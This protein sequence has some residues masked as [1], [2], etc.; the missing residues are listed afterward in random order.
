MGN[1]DQ[2]LMQS[3]IILETMGNAKTLRNNNSSRFGKYMKI[4]FDNE[5]NFNLAGA[6]IETYLLE[7]S[8]IVFQI[9]G[10]RN[11]HIFYQIANGASGDQKGQWKIG[12]ASDY[13]YINQS[14]CIA[15]DGVDEPKMFDLLG[16]ALASMGI[17]DTESTSLYTG[18]AGI[19][20]MGNIQ[21]EDETTS[22]GDVA[23]VSNMEVM[24]NAAELFG[25]E[26]TDLEKC[27]REKTLVAA[28]RGSVYYVKRDSTQAGYARDAMGKT[29]YQALFDWVVDKVRV[30]LGY[31]DKPLP[32]IAVLDIFG[33][34]HFQTNDF[35]QLLINFTNEALQGSFNKAVFISEQDL[36]K[37]EGIAVDAITPPDN[38]ICLE[39]LA[40]KKTG[41]MA[42][43]EQSGS[44][45]QP[46]DEKFN[47]ALHREHK[48]ARCF[49]RPHPKDIATTFIISHYAAEV[50]Y[51]VGKFL[52]K[53][54]DS[55]PP[56][57]EAL[58]CDCKC[59]AVEFIF[60]KQV[61]DRKKVEE[62]AEKAASKGVR[63][64]KRGKKKAQTV[65]GTFSKQITELIG[66][67]NETKMSY[68]LC[69]KPNFAMQV[70]VFDRNSVMEQLQCT[71]T[72]QACEVLRVGLPTRVDYAEIAGGFKKVLP[73]STLAVVS[74]GV[75]DKFLVQG[76]L[77]AFSVDSNAYA[78]G[79]TKLFFKT[80][81]IAVLESLMQKLN[82]AADSEQVDFLNKRLKFFVIRRRWRRAFAYVCAEKAWIWLFHIFR[83]QSAAA[84]IQRMF[85]CYIARK[86]Y[87]M[88]KEGE[89]I[90]AN[91]E[92]SAK[93]ALAQA[94]ASAQAAAAQVSGAAAGVAG[95]KAA[96]QTAE[97]AVTAA[98]SFSD[99]AGAAGDS[100]GAEAEVAKIGA[101]L[102]KAKGAMA[103]AQVRQQ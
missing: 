74:T 99:A 8:R 33:F 81:K 62:E 79:R 71:G 52:D 98:K 57:V 84:G 89:K 1:L 31:V 100:A 82:N 29:I 32:F 16:K 7:K 51:T 76:I 64:R 43:L 40:N 27:L 85:R 69:I 13:R 72:V 22:A 18:I 93:D 63:S 19:L 50:T 36:Y 91:A 35:E 17:S 25:I 11:Y 14:T 5:N 49:P 21:F 56:D 61:E 9:E 59:A 90:R 37:A 10:E 46:S 96:A 73:E 97:A 41:V 75:D 26:G 92:A 47:E 4:Q 83:K 15:I 87:T 80:G 20:Q 60:N 30:A 67:L 101:E 86:K 102:E 94:Q 95:A 6:S 55:I 2:R 78:L 70:G 77:F 68:I 88:L 23:K 54:N 3:N 24:N 53:N 44:M 28:G 45:P 12:N 42:I 48:D 39:L 34:E 58:M 65:S 38:S 103:T 66:N